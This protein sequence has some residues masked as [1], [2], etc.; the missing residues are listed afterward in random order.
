M[1]DLT[2]EECLSRLEQI[3]GALETGQLSLEESLRVFEEGVTLARQCAR[4][5]EEAEQKIELLSRD[6]T[7]ALTTRPLGEPE[8]GSEA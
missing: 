3:V 5:L 8:S 2:F 6:E 7:G 1:S 4:Y